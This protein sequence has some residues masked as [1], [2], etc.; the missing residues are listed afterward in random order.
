[1]HFRGGGRPAPAAKA[2]AGG[3]P[4]PQPVL[5]PVPPQRRWRRV[6]S[7]DGDRPIRDG[8]RQKDCLT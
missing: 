4:S 7:T 1:M 3:G 6:F 8:K 2:C 5:V